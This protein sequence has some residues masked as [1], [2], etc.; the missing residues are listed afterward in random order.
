MWRTLE[1]NRE[2]IS[3]FGEQCGVLKTSADRPEPETVRLICTKFILRSYEVV[4]VLR[5]VSRLNL[6]LKFSIQIV[7]YSRKKLVFLT[8]ETILIFPKFIFKTCTA[9]PQIKK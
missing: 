8:F 3:L 1:G 4:F 5:I 6:I 2:S 9:I 7:L